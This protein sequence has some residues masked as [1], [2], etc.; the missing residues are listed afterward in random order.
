MNICIRKVKVN[1]IFSSKSIK[2]IFNHQDDEFSDAPDLSDITEGKFDE[3][4]I[5]GKGHRTSTPNLSKK[6]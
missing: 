4:D 3:L 2:L 1:K 5:Q 6:R